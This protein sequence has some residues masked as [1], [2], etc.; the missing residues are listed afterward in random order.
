M[1]LASLEKHRDL[2]LLILRLGVGVMFIAHGAPKLIGGP[3][4]WA[5]VGGAMGNLGIAWAPAFWGL[6][7]ALSEAGGG[8]CLILGVAFRPACLL[9]G[10]TMM[11]AT[12]HH[13]KAGDGLLGAS[14]AIELGTVFLDLVFIG[15]GQ[16]SIDK[17]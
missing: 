8:V 9:M 10:F 13:L 7:A 6:M 16:H 2:G 11:V 3:E 17:K 5:G 15:P 14:H 4:R 1:I 12:I